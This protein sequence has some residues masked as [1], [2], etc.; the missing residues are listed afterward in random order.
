VD[1]HRLMTEALANEPAMTVDVDAVITR[2]RRDHRRATLALALSAALVFGV[3]GPPV[4][5]PTSEH[6]PIGF[7]R[8]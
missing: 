7:F 1:V 5:L 4:T 6:S 8:H 2:A 3:T